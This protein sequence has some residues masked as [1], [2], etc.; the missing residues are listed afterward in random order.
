[1]YKKGERQVQAVQALRM[2]V[3]VQEGVNRNVSWDLTGERR[4]IDFRERQIRIKGKMLKALSRSANKG[5]KGGA[6]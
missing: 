6:V 3:A 5:Y 2:R 1:M 4:C